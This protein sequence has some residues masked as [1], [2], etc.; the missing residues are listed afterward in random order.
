MGLPENGK[1]GICDEKP[2]VKKCI[3]VQDPTPA[4]IVQS[5]VHHHLGKI[6]IHSDKR[7]D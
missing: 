4:S 1:M 7:N 2:I 3:P 5:Q 6:C